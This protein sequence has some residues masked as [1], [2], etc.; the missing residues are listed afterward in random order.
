MHRFRWCRRIPHTPVAVFHQL[1]NQILFSKILHP[2]VEVRQKWEKE[3]NSWRC[4]YSWMSYIC[5]TDT[6]SCLF[7]PEGSQR[8][9]SKLQR[10]CR[11]WKKIPLA[12]MPLAVPQIREISSWTWWG[13]LIYCSWHLGRSFHRSHEAFSKDLSDMIHA[14]FSTTRRLVVSNQKG[15]KKEPC[16]NSVKHV[17]SLKASEQEKCGDFA[18]S[19]DSRNSFGHLN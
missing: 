11:S 15:N 1:N 12:D 4:S 18:I 5:R 10:T 13:L 14:V 16:S 17:C 3:L 6:V 19:C 8:H 7:T 9:A 2:M